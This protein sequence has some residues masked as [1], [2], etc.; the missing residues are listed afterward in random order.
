MPARAAPT[1][2]RSERSGKGRRKVELPGA[3]VDLDVG[4]DVGLDD[5]ASH[6]GYAVR[7]FQLW[8]FQDFIKTLAAVDITPTQYS[9]MTVI[10]ANPGLT[11]MAVAKR[12]GIERARLVHLLDTLEQRNL[13]KRAVSKTDRRSHSLRLTA[14]GGASLQQFKTLAAEHERHV[15]EKIGKDNR[16][17]LLEILAPFR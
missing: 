16:E 11:Q 6:V 3:D 17:R 9:V 12:L 10:A 14:A 15:I 4:L 2:P 8:I 1:E 7:R 5:L 13:V